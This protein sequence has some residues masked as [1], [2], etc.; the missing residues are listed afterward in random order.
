MK[1]IEKSFKPRYDRRRAHGVSTFSTSSSYGSH[2]S[3]RDRKSSNSIAK[4]CYLCKKP[5]DLDTCS[6][7]SRKTVHERKEF[8]RSKGLCFGCLIQGHKSK[9]CNKII[10]C[11][12][13]FMETPGS[14]TETPRST[15]T[16]VIRLRSQQ[17]SLPRPVSRV[18]IARAKATR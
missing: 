7:F 10:T 6:E 8:A 16:L 1:E 5:H 3:N 13:L 9:E 4:S 15:L 12:T 14:V 18:T 11:R 2:R 17:H